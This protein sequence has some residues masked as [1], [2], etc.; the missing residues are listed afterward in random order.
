MASCLV[1]KAGARAGGLLGGPGTD[2]PRYDRL[3]DGLGQRY[4]ACYG[5]NEPGLQ[6]D[7]ING[8]LAEELLRLSPVALPDHVRPANPA[9]ARA[10]F[11]SEEGPTLQSVGRCLA[12]HSPGMVNKVL[13]TPAGR[14]PK[15]RHS[16]RCLPKLRN[17]Q[18]ASPQAAYRR[19]SNAVRLLPD[20]IAGSIAVKSGAAGRSWG[21][22]LPATLWLQSI[23]WRSTLPLVSGLQEG[24]YDPQ[25]SG[26]FP[27]RRSWR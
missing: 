16:K 25:D 2:D 1:G 14:P 13:A 7:V 17:A 11:A 3:A 22:S 8:A 15:V 18:F 20:F 5:G 27:Q 12:V 9:A 6:M 23:R 24:L 10:Y 21:L 19:L 26:T 4:P